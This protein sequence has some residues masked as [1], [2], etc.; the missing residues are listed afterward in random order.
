MDIDDVFLTKVMLASLE[1]VRCWPGACLFYGKALSALGW[2]CTGLGVTVA[3][4]RGGLGVDSVRDGVLPDPL[5]LTE[6]VDLPVIMP[7]QVLAA[8]AELHGVASDS[9][10]RRL[11]APVPGQG[12]LMVQT[13]PKTDSAENCL[14]VRGCSEDHRDFTAAA[15]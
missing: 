8:F 6:V 12:W 3:V 15:H 5:A 1:S 9:V 11:G 10:H 7:R 4:R 13:V 2:S 14:E